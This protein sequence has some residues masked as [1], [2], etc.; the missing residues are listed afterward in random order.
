MKGI[1]REM[2]RFLLVYISM[3]FCVC[4][5][6]AQPRKELVNIVITPDHADWKYNIG[7]E[8]VFNIIVYKNNIPLDVHI[9]YRIRQERMPITEEGIVKLKNGSVTVKASSLKTPGFIR[10]FVD[11][12]IDGYTYSNYSTVGYAVDSIKPTTTLPDDFTEFWDA[13]KQKL[14]KISIDPMLRLLPERCTDKVNVYEVSMKNIHGKIYGILCL[15]KKKGKYPAILH[16]PG[17]GVRPHSGD[18]ASAAKGFITLR[19]GIHGIS[20]TLDPQVYEDLK[21]GALRNY[22]FSDLDD[23]NNYYYKRV[24]LGCIRAID[25]IYALDE[26]DGENVAVTGG[27]QGGALSIVTAGLDSRITCLAASYPA[28]SDLTGYLNN[29]AGGWPAM[30][31]VKEIQKSDHIVTSKYYDIVNFARF[32]NVP[33]WYTWGFNDY[34][35]PPTSTFAAFNIIT[36]EKELHL[37]Q[38]TGH[39]SYP[40]QDELRFSWL[41]NELGN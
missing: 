2:K 40:E 6:Q 41:Y 4:I 19:I 3:V 26:F 14:A 30:F 35:C 7:D 15:P 23:K 17:A 22:Y 37:F 33:G 10:C 32:I 31:Q 39:W 21:S 29:R 34:T 18:I 36:A 11:V 24:Y 16:V 25:F 5:V 13:W 38:D 1:R 20:V 9:K 12:E 28:L 27:S 8:V